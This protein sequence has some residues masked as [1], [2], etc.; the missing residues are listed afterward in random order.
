MPF[1]PTTALIVGNHA[2][3]PFHYFIIQGE[4][5]THYL[6][7]S[8]NFQTVHCSS[9]LFSGLTQPGLWFKR[10][11]SI[12]MGEVQ[13]REWSRE[14]L[15]LEHTSGLLHSIHISL[16]AQQNPLS[17]RIHGGPNCHPFPG[18]LCLSW[19]PLALLTYLPLHVLKLTRY[20]KGLE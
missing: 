12:F 16:K 8:Q 4:I 10:Q 6:R 7:A 9:F 3:T 18:R 13:P 11:F 15:R 2:D 14:T 1:N 19:A 17:P 5:E 20:V